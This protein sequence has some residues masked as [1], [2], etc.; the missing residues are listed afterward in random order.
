MYQAIAFKVVGLNRYYIMV[1][2][3]VHFEAAVPESRCS[4][5]VR[6]PS[7]YISIL[8]FPPRINGLVHCPMT[9]VELLE[10][11]YHACRVI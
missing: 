8:E 3:T 2:T 4:G 10:A 11:M 1:I 6:T 7:A 5:T 9:R